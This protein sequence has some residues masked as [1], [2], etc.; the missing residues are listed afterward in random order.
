MLENLI[1]ED[2]LAAQL[3][4]SRAT[5]QTWRSRGLGPAWVKLG[6]S[7][8]YDRQRVREWIAASEHMPDRTKSGAAA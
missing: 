6:Q 5:L 3:R 2:E 1:G 4:K 7:I 8:Y